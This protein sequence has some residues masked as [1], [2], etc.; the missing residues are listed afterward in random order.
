MPSTHVELSRE[1]LD[2]SHHVQNSQSIFGIP[3]SVARR[4]VIL[5]TRRIA[6]HAKFGLRPRVPAHRRH[7]ALPSTV[8]FEIFR[9]RDM[10]EPQILVA[11]HPA[12]LLEVLATHQYHLVFP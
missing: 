8:W 3:T 12:Y 5:S 11:P 4:G 9:E 10:S 7:V 6:P 2:A 1:I